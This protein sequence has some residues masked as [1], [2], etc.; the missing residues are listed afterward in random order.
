VTFVF[1]MV[2]WGLGLATLA[3]A[4][5]IFRFTVL[6]NQVDH[7]KNALRAQLKDEIAENPGLLIIIQEFG[8]VRSLKDKERAVFLGIGPAYYD[9][10]YEIYGIRRQYKLTSAGLTIALVAL[11]AWVVSIYFD[12]AYQAGRSLIV[13]AFV[14]FLFVAVISVAAIWQ[15]IRLRPMNPERCRKLEKALDE[16][17]ATHASH[18]ECPGKIGAP[19]R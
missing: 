15:N 12:G 2:Q 14:G 18:H 5:T 3:V 11:S 16:V 19:L 6:H 9:L 13:P 7:R 10:A 1:A 4:T 17:I 8:K